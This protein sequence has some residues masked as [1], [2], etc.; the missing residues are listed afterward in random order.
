MYPSKEYAWC[1][2]GASMFAI[3]A[4]YAMSLIP[5]EISCSKTIRMWKAMGRWEENDNYIPKKVT[6]F[7]LIGMEPKQPIRLV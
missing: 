3:D 6:M 5:C 1:Q 2:N 7:T 4:G